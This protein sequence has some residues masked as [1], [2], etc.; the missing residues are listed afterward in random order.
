MPM[1]KTGGKPLKPTPN[2]LYLWIVTLGTT[3]SR[4]ESQYAPLHAGG[5]A[6]FSTP[7]M[8]LYFTPGNPGRFGFY[9]GSALERGSHPEVEER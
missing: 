3:R 5:Q 2:G 4:G 8:Y 6:S 7:W 1:S 9:T